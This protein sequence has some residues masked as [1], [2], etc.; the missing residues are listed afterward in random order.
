MD[1]KKSYQSISDLGGPPSFPTLHKKVQLAVKIIPLDRNR[2]SS[3]DLKDLNPIISTISHNDVAFFRYGNSTR[4]LK[5]PFVFTVCTKRV[6]KLAIRIEHLHPVIVI[7][8][9]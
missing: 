8:T 6:D 3:W 1:E 9:H 7:V 2:S 5:T 4:I